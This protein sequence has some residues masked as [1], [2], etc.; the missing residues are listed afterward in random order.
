MASVAGLALTHTVGRAVISGIATKGKPFFRTPKCENPADLRQALRVVWQEATLFTLCMAALAATFLTRGLA[1]PAAVLW[2][3]ML[4]VQSLP[5]AA[6]IATAACSALAN[7]SMQG[8]PVI[9]LNPTVRP[10]PQPEMP[11]AA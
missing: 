7:A 11:K 3:V 2:M 4:G 6:S 8:A 1:D 9:A 10:E 5:Y